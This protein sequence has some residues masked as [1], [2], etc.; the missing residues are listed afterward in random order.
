VIAKLLILAGLFAKLSLL[1]VGGANSTL[2]EI[3]QQVVEQR[4]WMSA[5]QFS[6]LFAIANSAPGPNMLIATLVGAHVAGIAGGIVASLA[7]I[8][9]AGLLVMGVSRIWDRF[10]EQRW[11]RVLQAAILPIT[12]GLILAAG[13]VLAR[14]ADRSL[15]LAAVTISAA[16]LIFRTRLHP[17]WVLA[18]GAVLGLVFG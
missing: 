10:R 16:F 1:A 12:A 2:P 6:Q 9:P 3:A 8:L 17:L 13:F 11:R 14:A 15:F 7:M 18:G 4:H 5:T